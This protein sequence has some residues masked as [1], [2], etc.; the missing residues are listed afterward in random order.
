M[1]FDAKQFVKTRF[2]AREARVPVP[3][4][5]PFFG[6]KEKPRWTVR[7]LTGHEL[8]RANEA[9]ERNRNTA[10]LVEGLLSAAGKKK[11]EALRG[12]LGLDGATPPDIAKRIE[13]LI[14]GSVDPECDLDLAL[15]L[16]ETF[17]VEFYLLTNKILE[18]TGRGHAPGK[19]TPSGGEPT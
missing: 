4:L 5:K 7:G 2:Q 10:A 8:G 15:K 11:T 9:A 19:P 12:L 17:P 3:E 13:I 1:G 18:L 16:C 6:K 14:M